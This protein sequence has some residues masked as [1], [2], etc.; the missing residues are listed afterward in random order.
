MEPLET[1][2]QS[3]QSF[4]TS[5]RN[6]PEITYQVVG[7]QDDV[8]PTRHD[9]DLE[10][11]VGSAETAK[12][13]EIVNEVRRQNG[14]KELEIFIIGVIAEDKVDVGEDMALKISSTSIRAYLEG[15]NESK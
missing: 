8:G 9:H 7:I 10:A 6:A 3:V 1:R 4:L 5:I 12:G 15:A 2:L 14:L 13:C 11:I